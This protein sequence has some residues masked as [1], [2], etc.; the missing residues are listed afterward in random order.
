MTEERGSRVLPYSR[1]NETVGLI[2]LEAL[3]QCINDVV[4]AS[5]HFSIDQLVQKL[6]CP[7]MLVPLV[8][9]SSTVSFSRYHKAYHCAPATMSLII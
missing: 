7:R 6:T 9:S 4:S 1:W 3:D 8:Y 2:Y 5:F